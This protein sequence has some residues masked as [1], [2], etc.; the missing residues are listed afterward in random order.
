MCS[1]TNPKTLKL[2]NLPNENTLNILT[3]LELKDLI[4]FSYTSKHNRE[5]CY[6]EWLWNR[7]LETRYPRFYNI[8][9]RGKRGLSVV[10]DVRKEF[11][12]WF[13]IK[14]IP[15]FEELESTKRRGLPEMRGKYGD[16]FTEST[17]YYFVDP[18]KPLFLKK[19]TRELNVFP[20]QQ[21]F[22]PTKPKKDNS[23]E[24][25]T[26]Y[27]PCGVK[28][29]PWK[30]G[31]HVFVDGV[32][33]KLTKSQW[34]SELIKYLKKGWIPIIPLVLTSDGLYKDSVAFESY[35]PHPSRVEKGRVGGVTTFSKQLP[36]LSYCGL[37]LVINK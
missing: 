23:K 25:V 12:N 28:F 18:S 34:M 35:K 17:S 2:F 10:V 19:T 32:K 8:G 11:I 31:C 16:L 29:V 7:I 5:L 26:V 1:T 27:K 4:N 21:R 22:N 14:D 36:L 9:V 15:T 20:S 24:V 30:I 3:F 6:D 33:K 37:V 13:K